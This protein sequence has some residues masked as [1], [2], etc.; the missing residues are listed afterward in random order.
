MLIRSDSRLWL[1]MKVLE[2]SYADSEW[3]QI[4]AWDN[5]SR[6]ELC[7]LQTMAK[8][9]SVNPWW[10]CIFWD[11][12]NPWWLFF[13]RT[14]TTHHSMSVVISL[15]IYR[16]TSRLLLDKFLMQIEQCID[17]QCD[18]VQCVASFSSIMCVSDYEVIGTGFLILSSMN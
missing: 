8:I 17:R 10:L 3:L 6:I 16:A 11:H 18:D 15:F 9:E 14:Q 1:E 5:G 2:E 7:R 4:V 12:V 13:L